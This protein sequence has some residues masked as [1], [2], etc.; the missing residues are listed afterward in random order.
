MPYTAEISRENPSCILFLVDQS[1]SMEDPFAGEAGRSKAE[2]LADAVNRLLFELT[3]RTTK[4]QSEGVRNYYEVGAIGYGAQVGPALGGPLAGQVLHPIREVANNPARI[5]ERK[6]QVEDGAGGLVEETVR[7]PV[8]FDAVAQNGTPMNEALRL[9]HS[10]L[11]PLVQSRPNSF[12]PIVINITDG[13]S[14]DGD[15]RPAAQALRDLATSDGSVLLFNLNLSS[16]AG[17]P[18]LYPDT[19]AALPDQFAR[20][21]FE[22]SSVLPPHIQEAASAEGYNVTPQSRGFVFQADIV[23][24]IKF[25]DIG[26]RAKALR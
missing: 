22:M 13:E 23:E 18:I 15:P 9:A 3:I 12:P 5:E 19:D 7:F 4:D 26:T 2:R 11:S 25:L 16:S 8:W 1:G 14:T 17:A 24:V 20:Q 21:L 6:R 10:I